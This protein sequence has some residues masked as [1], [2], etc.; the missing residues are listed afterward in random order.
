[1]ELKKELLEFLEANNLFGLEDRENAEGV[2]DSYLK[3]YKKQLTLT[4]VGNCQFEA[5]ATFCIECDRKGMK[6]LKYKDYLNLG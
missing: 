2:V 4:D 1:M 5:Y 6:P 3:V